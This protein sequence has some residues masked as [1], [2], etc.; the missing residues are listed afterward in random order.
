MDQNFQERLI[1]AENDETT[2]E[3]T[4]SPVEN[5]YPLAGEVPMVETPLQ[6]TPIW[7]DAAVE[8]QVMEP[9]EVEKT[10][11]WEDSAVEVQVME[12][13]DVEETPLWVDPAEVIPAVE[14]HVEGVSLWGQTDEEPPV[15]EPLAED[16]L[17]YETPVQENLS[18]EKPVV[19]DPIF[20]P[21]PADVAEVETPV[22]EI[23]AWR[24]L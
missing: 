22:Q 7:E 19:A 15:K 16:D 18:G 2:G 14:D 3:E 12:P 11:L 20:E 23:P 10:P 6:E 9:L 4:I 21:L 8:V 24:K 5:L 13:L 1:H 17:L